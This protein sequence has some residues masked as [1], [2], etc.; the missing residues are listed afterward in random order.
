[1]ILKEKKKLVNKK[2]TKKGA[3]NK[4]EN[5]KYIEALSAI[6]WYMGNITCLLKSPFGEVVNKR[7]YVCKVELICFQFSLGI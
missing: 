4:V 5:F 7:M 1:M 6:L 3:V 2:Y